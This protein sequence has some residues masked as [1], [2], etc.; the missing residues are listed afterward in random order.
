MTSLRVLLFRRGSGC[1]DATSR[2]LKLKHGFRARD[3]EQLELKLVLDDPSTQLD[4]VKAGNRVQVK[5]DD[6][7]IFDGVI[8]ERKI[9]Q[10][11]RLECEVAAYTSLIRYERY[12]V[13]RFY[14]AGTRAGEIIRDLGKLIDGEIPVNL[15]GV[16]DGD[17]LL[18]P[19][20]IENET[21]LK[22]M[23]S[24]A[25]GTSCWLRM[26]PCLSYLSFDGVDD[27]VEVPDSPSLRPTTE[28][29]IV[30]WLNLRGWTSYATIVGKHYFKQDYYALTLRGAEGSMGFLTYE[31]STGTDVLYF[32]YNYYNQWKQI[33]AVFDD[34]VKQV[35]I[36]GDKIAEKTAPHTTLTPV[37]APLVV[38]AFLDHA[39]YLNGTVSQV[40]VY[41][42]AL[43]DIEIQCLYQNPLA[44]P[45]DSLVLWLRFNEG[46]GS[47]VYDWSGNENHGTIYGAEWGYEVY[48]KYVNSMLLEFRPKVTT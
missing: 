2:C 8:H 11:D 41:N 47:V 30:V 16:E 28:V 20:R 27:Y 37:D 4:Y 45:T 43:T 36:D 1:W 31:S 17:S 38:G 9:S 29:T 6:R 39:K 44:P 13:Y 40:L 23:R 3:L 18:S 22:V 25:R 5:L 32:T 15:S 34:G 14:Q 26:K 7:T 46:S 24:V 35:Y 12:I 21:A 48:P 19:W 42:R 10:S 33:A